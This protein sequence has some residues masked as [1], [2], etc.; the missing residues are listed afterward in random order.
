MKAARV[1]S[2]S[3]AQTG[4]SVTRGKSAVTTAIALLAGIIIPVVTLSGAHGAVVK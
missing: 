3:T 1:K 4:A 2:C